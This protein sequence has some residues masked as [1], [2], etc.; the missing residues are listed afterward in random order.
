MRVRR[1]TTRV[2]RTGLWL[3]RRKGP[4]RLSL[5]AASGPL[6]RN[7]AGTAPSTCAADART[8]FV[9]QPLA[10]RCDVHVLRSL[11]TVCMYLAHPLVMPSSAGAHP[12]SPRIAARVGWSSCRS[13]VGNVRYC[14]QHRRSSSTGRNAPRA[15]LRVDADAFRFFCFVA[16]FQPFFFSFL[17]SS[18]LCVLKSGALMSS[19]YIALRARGGCF[20]IPLLSCHASFM[21][22]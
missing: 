2:Y 3:S 5:K 12:C 7:V 1:N 9:V 19:R 6:G 8:M 11:L 22:K 10:V 14:G 21:W 16:F 13:R 20:L 17:H 18:V 4:G 15:L